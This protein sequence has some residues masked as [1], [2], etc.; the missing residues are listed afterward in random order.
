[1][2]SLQS[3]DDKM[4]LPRPEDSVARTWPDDLPARFRPEAL[5]PR[6]AEVVEDCWGDDV[7]EVDCSEPP[8]AVFVEAVDGAE[9]P[10]PFACA[11]WQD[12]FPG[13]V[14]KTGVSGLCVDGTKRTTAMFTPGV[15]G[16][17]DVLPEPDPDFPFED[18][19][20]MKARVQAIHAETGCD[21]PVSLT[22]DNRVGYRLQ[23]A[24]DAP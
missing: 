5:Q 23:W 10:S 17:P 8:C 24:P 20:R 19:A 9:W 16:M 12:A 4:G 2:Q 15:P 14:G 6:I 22:V 21:A 7:I 3:I 13:G 11:A 18:I 1:M